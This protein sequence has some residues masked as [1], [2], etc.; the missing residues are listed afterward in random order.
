MVLAARAVG[1]LRGGDGAEV[2][3]GDA[4]GGSLRL[5]ARRLD[6]AVERHLPGAGVIEGLGEGELRVGRG[7][8][9]RARGRGDGLRRRGDLRERKGRG[10]GT[11][12]NDGTETSLVVKKARRWRA[13]VGIGGWGRGAAAGRTWRAG[14]GWV[15]PPRTMSAAVVPP[16]HLGAAEGAAVGWVGGGVGGAAAAAAALLLYSGWPDGSEAAGAGA[17]ARPPAAP[18]RAWDRRRGAR[19]DPSYRSP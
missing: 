2:G 19:G 7:G 9:A 3:D 1:A 12:L 10:A 14:G 11:G 17:G 13:G 4:A 6:G 5:L 8:D 18:P 15:G 16:P